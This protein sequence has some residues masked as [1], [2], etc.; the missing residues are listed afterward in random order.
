MVKSMESGKEN[1]Y[2]R[3][4]SCLSGNSYLGSRR[5]ASFKLKYIQNKMV[6][7]ARKIEELYEVKLGYI[8]AMQPQ[9]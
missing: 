2:G 8:S 5:D 4:I 6:W 1:E 9:D 3:R 7:T